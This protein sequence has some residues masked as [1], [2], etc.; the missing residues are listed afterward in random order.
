MSV[1]VRR[2]HNNK[3]RQQIKNERPV[4]ETKR[5]IRMFVRQI[6]RGRR[7]A[8]EQCHPADCQCT[9]HAILRYPTTGGKSPYPPR[10]YD[11]STQV[12]ESVMAR[13]GAD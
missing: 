13:G 12:S 5:W 9:Q 3:G 2:H 7:L 8:E 1:K 10:R 4:R 11:G 6:E